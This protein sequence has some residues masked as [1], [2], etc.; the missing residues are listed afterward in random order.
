MLEAIR[1]WPEID[2][3]IANF[4]GVRIEASLDGVAFT[5]IGTFEAV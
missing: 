3:N 5:E 4:I 2:S 1:F